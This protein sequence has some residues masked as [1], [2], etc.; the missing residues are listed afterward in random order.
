LTMSTFF[1][2]RRWL[3]ILA[4][5]MLALS[6]CSPAKPKPTATPDL[7]MK[8]PVP[9]FTV[10]T[11]RGPT[12]TKV[13]TWTLLPQFITPLF[14]YTPTPTRGP[15]FVSPGLIGIRYST[16]VISKDSGRILYETGAGAIYISNPD[17]SD[18]IQLLASGGQNQA[19][20]PNGKQI[21]YKCA[22]DL[23][24]MNADGSGNRELGLAQ[25][26]GDETVN[27]VWSPDGKKLGFIDTEKITVVSVNGK[28]RRDFAS[29]RA[30][31]SKLS[32]SY[33]SRYIAFSYEDRSTK[34][35][36]VGILDTKPAQGSLTGIEKQADPQCAQN[37]S[38]PND[39]DP[40]WSPKQYT[41]AYEESSGNVVNICLAGLDGKSQGCL[42][43]AAGSNLQMVWSGDGKQML[44][45]SSRSADTL[46]IY[47]MNADGSDQHPLKF[48]GPVYDNAQ[49]TGLTR[50][51]QAVDITITGAPSWSRN[52]GKISFYA[53]S[54]YLPGLYVMD[55]DGK[56]IVLVSKD[57]PGANTYVQWQP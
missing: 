55:R 25:I 29:E 11:T 21:V 48:V 13:S 44:F 49:G 32:W 26:K 4:S 42:T 35:S 47:T 39:G 22:D 17:G 51:T 18:R 56:N 20:S 38:C 50:I 10:S 5:L 31:G 34:L 45:L 57:P 12:R 40:A 23:C 53:D 52:G 15:G 46:P 8:T 54:T 37:Q 14:T 16:P 9:S 6:A 36:N 2:T 24:I 28:D 33:D 41:L 3:P 27:P 19:W 43:N 30:Q 7:S 1:R